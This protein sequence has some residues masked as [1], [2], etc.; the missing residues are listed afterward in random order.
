MRGTNGSHSF[1][2]DEISG[3]VSLKDSSGCTPDIT[4]DGVL[5]LEDWLPLKLHRD[6]YVSIPLRSERTGRQTSSVTNLY[7]GLR[8]AAKFKME[9]IIEDCLC[10]LEEVSHDVETQ[11]YDR[12]GHHAIGI[13]F[14]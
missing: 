7:A 9:M 4:D 13:K 14:K 5:W 12:N 3:L 10:D 11:V 2:R 1:W 6:G 8:I